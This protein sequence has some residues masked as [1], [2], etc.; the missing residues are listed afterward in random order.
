MAAFWKSIAAAAGLSSLA[1]MQRSSSS[2][3][4]LYNAQ[5]KQLADQLN[6]ALEKS[7]CTARYEQQIVGDNAAYTN[8]VMRLT[9]TRDWI[10]E[11]LCMGGEP[12]YLEGTIRKPEEVKPYY[13][14]ILFLKAQHALDKQEEY[15]AYLYDT[16]ELIDMYNI[17]N[18][19]DFD[20]EDY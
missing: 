1:N 9:E 4:S 16:K 5:L 15:A 11:Y 8:E 18:G 7:G 14:S 2:D 10:L 17:D 19:T 3:I 12:S 6:T 20:P 13:R